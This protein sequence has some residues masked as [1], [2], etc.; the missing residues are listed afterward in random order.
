MEVAGLVLAA[1]AGRRFGKPKALATYQDQFLVQRAVATL[2]EA[3]CAPILVVLGASA[4]QVRASAPDLPA[5]VIN[6]DW[7][8]GMGSSLRTGLAA[9]AGSPAAAAVILLVDMPGVSAAAVRRVI[10]AADADALA[11]GDYGDR[12]G[13]PVLLGRNHWAGVAAT[14]V[15]DRGARA[16]LRTH[17]AAVRPIPVGDVAD[18]HDIDRPSDLVT[19]SPFTEHLLPVVQPWFR[20]PEVDRWLGGPQWPAQALELQNAGIGEMFRG[21][22][23]LRTHSWVVSSSTGDP[24]AL[25]GGDVYDRWSRYTETPDGPAVQAIEPGPAMGMAYVVDPRRW[26]QGFGRA[27]LL[28][29]VNAP[30]VAD[31][32]LFAA[33]IEPANIAS[34]RC[35]VAAGFTR[36]P[37]APDWEGMTYYIHRR[38]TS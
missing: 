23:V 36:D 38:T 29:A 6:E 27:A 8:S 1:G 7:A 25:V 14:A 24:V 17:A 28:A 31:V 10:A 9:L 34:T 4:S 30:E 19:L 22:R 18:D 16:Y 20:H 32:V 11:M 2:R 12:R 15:G 3:G 13:H 35:A 37:A 5:T 26:R 33:G 21:R